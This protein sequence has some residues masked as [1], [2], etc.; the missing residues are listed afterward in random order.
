[1]CITESLSGAHNRAQPSCTDLISHEV[2]YLLIAPL[3]TKN[4]EHKVTCFKNQARF[5]MGLVQKM[6][7]LIFEPCPFFCCGG[8]S[9]A[10]SRTTQRAEKPK[11]IFLLSLVSLR[12]PRDD[13]TDDHLPANALVLVHFVF[14]VRDASSRRLCSSRIPHVQNEAKESGYDDDES[15][16]RF[17]SDRCQQYSTV[18]G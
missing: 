15:F 11:I 6:M 10:T 14:L 3:D 4:I 2:V 1:M 8:L 9:F 12:P 16:S 13:T 5:K 7:S 17:R 18:A